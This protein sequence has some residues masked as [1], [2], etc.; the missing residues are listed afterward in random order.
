MLLAA[1]FDS[2]LARNQ[3]PRSRLGAGAVITVFIHAAVAGSVLW[4]TAH[5]LNTEEEISEV[6]FFSTHPAPP[7]PP[8]PAGSAA[9][10]E[11]KKVEK[12]PKKKL[13][14]VAGKKKTQEKPTPSGAQAKTQR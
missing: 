6:K 14:I 1:M 8:P 12:K 13:G 5:P 3:L 7:P 11:E 2:V 4:L 9:K 10:V